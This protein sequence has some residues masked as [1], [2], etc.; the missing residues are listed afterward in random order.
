MR[1]ASVFLLSAVVGLALVIPTQ[2]AAAQ[3]TRG[4]GDGAVTYQVRRP[5]HGVYTCNGETITIDGWFE[6]K[7]LNT[8]S[9]RGNSN[10]AM[11]ING[12]GMG[13]GESGAT[14]RWQLNT[15]KHDLVSAASFQRVEVF[16]S[17]GRLIGLGNAPSYDIIYRVHATW[18]ANGE[19]TAQFD[20]IDD[21]CTF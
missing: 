15:A 8:E 18:N 11:F 10:S 5:Y 6:I 19:V 17:R 16:N 20:G 7:M 3:Q 2:E 14:Y 4:K 12:K 9:A 21:T 1:K 13:V